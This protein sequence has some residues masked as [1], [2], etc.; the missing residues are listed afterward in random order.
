MDHI[1]LIGSAA[2]FLTTAAFLPQVIKAHASKHTKDISL[3]M[4]VL[5]AVGVTFWII[6][7]IFLESLPMIVANSL[8]LI[9]SLYLLYLKRKYG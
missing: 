5:L 2:A 1:F 7:G 3:A 8:V 9:M 4:C 6:Y